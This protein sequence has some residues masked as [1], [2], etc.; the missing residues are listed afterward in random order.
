M[1]R[2]DMRWHWP[3][4]LSKG[5]SLGYNK[6]RETASGNGDSMRT[7]LEN[8]LAWTSS[9]KDEQDL[10][11]GVQRVAWELDFEWF[12]F[13]ICTAL[14]FS[15]P[16]MQMRCN[17]SSTWQRRYSDA[18][19]LLVDPSVQRARACTTPF[20]WQGELLRK[21]P[22]F[23]EEARAAGLRYGWACSRTNASR[24][25]SMLTLARSSSTLDVAELN[26]K[27]LKMRWLA[28]T[29]APVM[30]RLLITPSHQAQHYRL[31]ARE[32][33]VLRWTA[34]GKTQEEIAQILAI[35]FDTVKFHVKNAVGK[36]GATNKT[37]AVVRA[38]VLGIIS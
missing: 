25:Q 24:H 28:E 27:E 1:D 20:L 29:I 10:V 33:E 3:C 14:P 12:S 32:I 23:W 13:G 38:A 2:T 30:E 35:S 34:D 9:V 22:Q 16:I 5:I 26:A 37:A 19:F 8:L 4:R 18:D 36:L 11:N 7:W 21:M 15:N 6:R 31:T 17:F